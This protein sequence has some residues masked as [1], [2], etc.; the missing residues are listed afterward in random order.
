MRTESEQYE[1]VLKSALTI[2][3]VEGLD[4]SLSYLVE[5]LSNQTTDRK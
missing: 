4:A 5:A 2:L 1:I 3:Q